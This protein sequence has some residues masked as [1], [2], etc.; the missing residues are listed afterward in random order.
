MK[1]KLSKNQWENMGKEAGWMKTAEPRIE[2]P[3]TLSLFV[4]SKQAS[5]S[6]NNE[7]GRTFVLSC[8]ISEQEFQAIAGKELQNRGLGANQALLDQKNPNFK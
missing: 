5:V 1:I 4:Q 7:E 8:R 6:V 3:A 2:K